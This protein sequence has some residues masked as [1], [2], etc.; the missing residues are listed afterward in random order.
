VVSVLNTFVVCGRIVAELSLDVIN[1]FFWAKGISQPVG[2]NVGFSFSQLLQWCFV[3]FNSSMTCGLGKFINKTCSTAPLP[4]RS[5]FVHLAVGPTYLQARE[6]AIVASDRFLTGKWG[7]ICIPPTSQSRPQPS[8]SDSA[9]RGSATAQK[10]RTRALPRLWHPACG[11]VRGSAWKHA[12]RDCDGFPTSCRFCLNQY[13]PM[14][15]VGLAAAV[16]SIAKTAKTIA[17]FA[18]QL[19]DAAK[20]AP[21]IRDHISKSALSLRS[22]STTTQTAQLAL[23]HRFPNDPDSPVVRYMVNYNLM[24]DL[25]Q[26]SRS[27]RERIRK[28]E[29]GVSRVWS[30][31]DMLTSWRWSRV[32]PSIDELTVPMESLKNSLTLI[33]NVI[34]LECL[35]SDGTTRS[36]EELEREM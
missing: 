17:H 34:V 18:D 11:P 28:V 4:H 1:C 13:F 6:R 33:V 16:I 32:K 20:N 9:L 24:G 7:V 31:F 8:T 23:K 12:W 15:V 3:P 30:K 35:S 10:A 19:Y 29:G 27:L 21:R 25:Q 5:S 2:Q 14:E 22:F 26:E 36:A